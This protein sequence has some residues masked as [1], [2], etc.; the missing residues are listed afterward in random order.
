MKEIEDKILALSNRGIVPSLLV[1]GSNNYEALK[2]YTN[3]NAIAVGSLP[4][5]SSFSIDAML[6]HGYKL[7]V[8]RVD[9]ENLC[10]AYGNKLD[11]Y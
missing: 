9:A 8:I 2:Q 5:R 7:D 6:L 11:I 1:I 4:K 3:D 10:E